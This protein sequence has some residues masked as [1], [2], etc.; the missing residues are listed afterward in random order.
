MRLLYVTDHRIDAYL[1]KALRE[2]GHVLDLAGEPADGVEMATGGGYEAIVLDWSGPPAP[3]AARFAAV[4]RGSLVVVISAAADEAERTVVLEAGADACFTRPA[5]FIELE[6]RLD[7][8]A[9]LVQRGRLAGDGADGAQMIAA[10]Q[11]ILVNGT[12]I[13]LSGREFR[14]MTHLTD[15]PGE[16][17]GPDRLWRQ[18][19]GDEL[20]PR[21]DLV[22]ASLSRL[23]R[24]LE[25]AGAGACL[26]V[27]GGH[28]WAFEPPDQ[29]QNEKRL[30]GP[31]ALI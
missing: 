4:A 30:I 5:P 26:R 10:Q 27:A 20:E 19:W 25:A 24:K 28:G 22:R 18:V 8:L 14:V 6:A 11:A 15:H 9:R 31:P 21:P 1:V 23:R 12:H 17:I 7:A 2:A 29:A 16:V 3:C 13:A